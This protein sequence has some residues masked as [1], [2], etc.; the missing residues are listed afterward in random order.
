MPKILVVDD[1]PTICWG[2]EKLGRSLGHQVFMASSAEQ[3]LRLAAECQ[4]ELLILDVRLPGMDGLSAMSEFRRLLDVSP[5]VVIT[6]FGDLDTA[7]RAVHNGAFEYVL[8]PFDLDDIRGTIRRALLSGQISPVAE[9]LEFGEG[10]IGKSPPMQDVFKQIALAAAADVSV[11]LEGET[12]VGKA[13]AAQAIHRHS[14]RADGPFV[15]VNLSAH[16]GV[17][18]E[19]ELFGHSAGKSSDAAHGR[20]GLLLEA[21]GGTLFLEDVAELPQVVQIKLM[22]ALETREVSVSGA[23][24]PQRLDVRVISAATGR[25]FDRVQAGEFRQDLFHKLAEFE[26]SMPALRERQADIP[27]LARHFAGQRRG[28]R[29]N[30]A[31][32]TIAELMLR[33]WYG[34]VREL[35]SAIEHALVVARAG[36]ILAEHLPPP[37][38]EIAGNPNP[39]E[40]LT[41]L[42]D[43]AKRRAADLLDDPQAEGFVYEKFLEE[44]EPALLE[45]AMDRFAQECAPAARA[46][47]LHRTTLKRKLDQYKLAK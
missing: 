16:D 21:H 5:I 40:S 43:L 39:A 28:T 29:V 17:Q 47:G 36:L 6:A 42:A 12:G 1:E 10:L 2:I 18:A 7:I 46:L 38:P 34:N 30:F 3:G 25:L 4:P 44:V 33:R 35:R 27:L 23:E 19:L 37:L 15:T 11:L 24:V 22:H 20:R 45:S 31:E 14:T 41:S 8:K 13:A 9:R 26:I 32:E